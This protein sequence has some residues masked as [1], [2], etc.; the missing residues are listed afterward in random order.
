MTTTS[1]PE[2]N[3][4]L[5]SDPAGMTQSTWLE[6]QAKVIAILGFA[7]LFVSAQFLHPN[8]FAGADPSSG[9]DYLAAFHNHPQLHLAHFLEFFCGALLIVLASHFHGLTRQRYPNWALLALILGATGAVMLIG[10]KAAICLSASA[11]DTL[12]EAQL[13]AMVPGLDVLINRQGNMMVLS[14]IPM[15]PIGFVVFGVLLFLSRQVP[16]WQAAFVTLGSI[17]L[18]NPGIQAM[19]TVG[20][21]FLA[22][23]VIPIGLDLARGRR[24]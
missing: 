23:G 4:A 17:L 7:V 21:V 20:A 8:P 3:P 13:M 11:F 18:T 9:A 15:L 10:N 16:R 2:G 24:K 5:H 14:L 19:N 6:R 22:I 12:S 1:F